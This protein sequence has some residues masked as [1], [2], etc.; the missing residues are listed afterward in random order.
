MALMPTNASHQSISRSR[1]PGGSFTPF[2]LKILLPLFLVIFVSHST[3][4]ADSSGVT[5]H[6]KNFQISVSAGPGEAAS[7][8]SAAVRIYQDTVD[9]FRAGLVVLRDGTIIGCS[10]ADTDSDGVLEV[11]FWTQTA[12]SGAYGVLQVVKF[13]GSTFKLINVPDPP[14]SLTEGYE[15]LD[16]FRATDRGIA[17]TF[18]V[19]RGKGQARSGMVGHRT[20]IFE[21]KRGVWI[22][23]KFERL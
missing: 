11:S 2:Y 19:F 6:Y 16:E 3:R 21:A 8:G 14:A 15:G 13:T 23:E 5:C 18:P 9:N 1:N 12:G 7:I 20:I 4:A 22:L 17:R 10:A